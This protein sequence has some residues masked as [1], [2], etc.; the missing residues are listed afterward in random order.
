MSA[1]A[2]QYQLPGWRQREYLKD[3]HRKRYNKTRNLKHSSAACE[4]KQ[5][6]R[7]HDIEMAHLEYIKYSN[8]ILHKAELTLSLLTGKTPDESRLENLKYHI[9]HGL[10]QIKLIYRRVIEHENIPHNEKVFSIFEPHTEWI[11]KGKAGTPVELGL[12]VCVLQDQFGFTLNHHVMQKQTDDQVAVPMAEGAK[13]RFPELSGYS[14]AIRPVIP[15][16][17]GHP[18]R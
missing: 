10:H 14:E 11:S 3:Q 12:R 5:R 18:L 2:E 8:K 17:S 1:L 13:K 6:Q 9:A 7:Q 16:T 15:V 4:L